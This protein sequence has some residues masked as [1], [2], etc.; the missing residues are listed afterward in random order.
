V[1]FAELSPCVEDAELER[2]LGRSSPKLEAVL[3]S[4]QP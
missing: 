4:E 3:V 2:A 1:G